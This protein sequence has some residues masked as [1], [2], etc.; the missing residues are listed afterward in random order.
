[1][2]YEAGWLGER[3]SGSY[4]LLGQS[5]LWLRHIQISGHWAILHNRNFADY[6]V[7]LFIFKILGCST[8]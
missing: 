3:F 8:D 1:M 5:G 4:C 2:G 7:V 6:V